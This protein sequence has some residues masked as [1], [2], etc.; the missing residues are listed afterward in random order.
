MTRIVNAGGVEAQH[1]AAVDVPAGT[2]EDD[3][4]ADD[5]CGLADDVGRRVTGTLF[6]IILAALVV[7]SFVWGVATEL[8]WIQALLWLPVVI[9]VLLMFFFL[10]LVVSDRLPCLAEALAADRSQGRL[11]SSI[12]RPSLDDTGCLRAGSF[13]EYFFFIVNQYNTHTQKRD[14]HPRPR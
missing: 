4:S 13:T 5:Q 7:G 6:V 3:K 9:M 2:P 12:H 1:H 14:K 11:P 10:W 8:T